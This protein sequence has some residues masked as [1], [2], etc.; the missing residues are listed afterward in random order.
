MIAAWRGVRVP[1]KAPVRGESGTSVARARLLDHNVNL[2]CLLD[3]RDRTR[4][5]VRS[6]VGEWMVV[7]SDRAVLGEGHQN[8]HVTVCVIAGV[9]ELYIHLYGS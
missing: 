1:S 4:H 8:Q 9:T 6:S 3:T 7:V 2:G 5:A